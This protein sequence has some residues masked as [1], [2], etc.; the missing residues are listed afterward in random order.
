MP[1]KQCH[2]EK[3]G[4]FSGEVAIRFPGLNGLKKPILLVFPDLVVC[5]HCGFTEFTVAAN[6]L[7]VLVTGNPVLGVAIS[8]SG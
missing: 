4:T 8:E 2:A 3:T 7:S 6:E 5:L 1:C